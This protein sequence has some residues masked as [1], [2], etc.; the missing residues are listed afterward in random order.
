M[1]ATPDM[2]NYSIPDRSHNSNNITAT[3]PQERKRLVIKYRLVN[4]EFLHH[5]CILEIG[6]HPLAVVNIEAKFLN[7]NRS[8]RQKIVSWYEMQ[9][10]ELAKS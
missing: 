7:R 10:L 9:I 8:G 6:D 5:R 4:G 3:T 2:K 1:S